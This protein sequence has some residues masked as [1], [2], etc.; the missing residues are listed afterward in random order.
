MVIEKIETKTSLL[1]Q[2]AYWENGCCNRF[3]VKNNNVPTGLQRL[4]IVIA[5]PKHRKRMEKERLNNKFQ[6]TKSLKY[7]HVFNLSIKKTKFI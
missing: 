5:M 3:G 7:F 1:C 6:K 4:V 2:N